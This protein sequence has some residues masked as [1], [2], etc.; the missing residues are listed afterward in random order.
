MR[1]LFILFLCLFASLPLN[2]AVVTNSALSAKKVLE[3]GYAQ[4]QTIKAE[5]KKVADMKANLA[6]GSVGQMGEYKSYM[7]EVVDTTPVSSGLVTALTSPEQAGKEMKGKTVSSA[8]KQ[9]PSPSSVVSGLQENLEI[10]SD[11]KDVDSTQVQKVRKNYMNANENA[12]T[13]ALALAFVNNT[14]HARELGQKGIVAQ[15]SKN[16]NSGT[17]ARAV[18]ASK[19]ALS[20]N[21]LELYTLLHTSTASYN[22]LDAIGRKESAGNLS[23]LVNNSLSNLTG[24]FSSLDSGVIG[25][26]LQ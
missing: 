23:A 18:D 7:R 10:S 26:F 11:A 6:K 12:S 3:E 14:R 16:S 2:G 25:G 5:Y 22:M 15:T 13:Y 1:Q 24:D 20:F 4:K 9:F 19:V 8:T 21:T 17:T